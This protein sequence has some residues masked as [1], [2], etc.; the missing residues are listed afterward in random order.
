MMR[1]L[2]FRQAAI[3]H[4]RAADFVELAKPGI[5]ALVL[6]TVAT[7]FYLGAPSSI[8]GLRLF[9]ALL[10]AAAVAAGSNALNQVWER[11]VDARMRRTSTRPLPA[12][13]VSVAGAHL[14]AWT[15]GVGGIAYLG[16]LVNGITAI[17]AAATLASYVFLYT[18]LK[19]KTSLS[20]LVGAVPGALP[21]VGGWAAARGSLDVAAWTLFALLFLWQL[22]HFL[23]LA[24]M[25]RGEYAAADLRMLSV[26]E[27]GRTTFRMA[28][29]YSVALLPVSLMPTVLG[30][31]GSL[32]FVG[33]IV[34]SLWLIWASA[35]AAWHRSI[36]KARRLFTV[37]MVYLL[38]IL[39][40][41]MIDKA[42]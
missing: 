17:L 14:F 27:G 8:S 38:G 16:V 30:T 10:G 9:H 3:P 34:L 41:M 35:T 11:D 42:P 4:A 20:T 29:L 21:I 1:D 39:L 22:P 26:L 7:G 37:S 31:T 23:A 18:P 33:A 36:A 40:M 32:Y 5:V 19:R 12:G 24:W 6:V 13:R 15:L 25:Y 2:K 28:L